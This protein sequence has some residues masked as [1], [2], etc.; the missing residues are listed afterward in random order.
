MTSF[1]FFWSKNTPMT[2]ASGGHDIIVH[3]QWAKSANQ[4]SAT[5]K[6]SVFQKNIAAT[7]PG[8]AKG[9]CVPTGSRMRFPGR[10][11]V[12]F[13]CIYFFLFFFVCGVRVD[14]GW[15]GIA[16]NDWNRSAG[17]SS[18]PP[19]PPPP[20]FPFADADVVV[21]VVVGVVVV[22]SGVLFETKKKQVR[23]RKR[24]LWAV[25]IRKLGTTR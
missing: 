3:L 16:R 6:R 9:K 17:T 5:R 11:S 23:C 1:P 20:A 22:V 10:F 7:V 14:W 13:F 4:R 15:R 21:L 8:S 24:V 25:L 19:P 18:C 2:M 12:F